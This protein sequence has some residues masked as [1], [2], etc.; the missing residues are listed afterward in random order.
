MF[1]IA[2]DLGTTNVKIALYDE[3]LRLLALEKK[4]VLYQRKGDFVEF[5]AAL[6]FADLLTLIRRC[7]EKAGCSFKRSEI[8]ITLTGQAE[9][10]VLVGYDGVP[11]QKA[12]SWM[13]TRSKTECREMIDDFGEEKGF[14]ITG[15]PWIAPTWTATKLRWFYKNKPGLLKRTW[16]VLL[17][18]DYIQFC[19]T[20]EVMSESTIQ[21][22]SYLY[23]MDKNVHW[24]EMVKYCGLQNGQLPDIVK[25]C[26]RIGNILPQIRKQLPE[27]G[28]YIV[29]V[30]ALDHIAG[31]VGSNAYHLGTAAESA[32]TVLS[33]T[34]LTKRWD[35]DPQRK[36]A[37]LPGPE[38]G[39]Y[40][41]FD[42]CDSG[43]VCMEWLKNIVLT[44]MSYDEIEAEMGR[45]EVN[46]APLF[47]PYMTGINP[48]EY[49]ADAKGAFLGLT[50]S[51]N[52]I[53]MAYAVMEGVACM[54]SNNIKYCESAGVDIE[55]V[56]SSGGGAN[57]TFW[58][59]IKANI[60][61][62]KIVVPKEKNASVF[63]AA[64]IGAVDAGV[65]RNLT[66]AC[67]ICARATNSYI[68]DQDKLYQER[69]RKYEW[70]KKLLA[71]SFCAGRE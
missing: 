55:Q 62:K 11:L 42:C 71:P 50:L 68:P 1:F 30:G 27:G 47:L 66:E 13:D 7:A 2:I 33:L 46:N 25:P 35:F 21:G 39:Y 41:L 12:V 9:S 53:D 56:I 57:S 22:F 52:K 34:M 45:V 23:E 29:N 61:R 64:L 26:M 32:G 28:E 17:L 15:Q 51:H 48:P 59:Q 14:R 3:E 24:E 43:G 44:D 58:N 4:K 8:Y 49:Y 38:E 63:G 40:V 6:Y 20:G 31:M 36:I 67:E 65:Y 16:K 69:Y 19:F 70:Y 18:K 60:C 37:C 54:L 10:F 5:D